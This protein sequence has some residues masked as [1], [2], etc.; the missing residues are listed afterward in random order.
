LRELH[1]THSGSVAIAVAVPDSLAV[2][3]AKALPGR[4]THLHRLESVTQRLQ[5]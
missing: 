5:E 1:S 4:S 3:F 2:A